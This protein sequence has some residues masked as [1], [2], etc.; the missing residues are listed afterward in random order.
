M[1]RERESNQ[2]PNADCTALPKIM[3][4]NV[5]VASGLDEWL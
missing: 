5:S 4:E 1:D 3:S 2:W